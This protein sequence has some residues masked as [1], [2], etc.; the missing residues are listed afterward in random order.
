MRIAVTCGPT[1]QGFLAPVE[2]LLREGGH[3]VKRFTFDAHPERTLTQTVNWNADAIWH[4]W[5]DAA[6]VHISRF[7][8]V[9][10]VVRLHRYEA[11]TDWPKLVQWSDRCRLVVTSTHIA[12]R[13]PA[14]SVVI[15]S[16]VD[17]NRFVIHPQRGAPDYIHRIAVV[18]YLEG[19][20]QPGLAL[21]AA[22]AL[23]E[24]HGAGNIEATPWL[25]FIGAEKE[26]WWRRYLIEHGAHVEPWTDDVPDIWRQYS[27]CLSASAAEGCPYNVVEAMACGAI[28]LVHGCA[29]A[30]E[31][32]PRECVWASAQE[33]SRCFR[34]MALNWTPISLRAWAAARYSIEA[35]RNAVLNLFKETA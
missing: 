5:C 8:R 31:Q 28:P 1:S 27:I 19:R 4:E 25:T 12:D 24:G 10:V 21:D 16:V 18:G 2:R 14:P 32:F 30:Y 3:E 22:I 9:P 7:A 11:D 33:I 13:V 26:P 35:N 6:A 29:G 34:D 15:P 17:F 23:Q 20:K